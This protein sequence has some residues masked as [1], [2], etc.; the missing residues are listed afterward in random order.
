MLKKALES[1]AAKRT[2]AREGKEPAIAPRWSP[3][4]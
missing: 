4:K 3:I 1:A 2:A